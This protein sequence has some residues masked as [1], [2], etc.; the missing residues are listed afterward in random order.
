MRQ[1]KDEKMNDTKTI[2]DRFHRQELIKGWR[3]DKIQDTRIIVI[4]KDRLSD[5]LISDLMSFGIGSIKRVGYSDFLDFEKINKDVYLEQLDEE[6]SN[7]PLAEVMLKDADIVIDATND[8]RSKYYSALS[9]IKIGMRY[10]S[11]AASQSSFSLYSLKKEKDAEKESAERSIDNLI[12]HHDKEC[13]SDTRQGPQGMLNS[14][15]CSAMATDEIRKSIFALENDITMDK[16]INSD[17]IEPGELLKGKRIVQVGAG[18]IGTFTAL[19]LS[20][21]GAHVKVIDF[22]VVEETNLNRQFLFYDDI[23]K[24]KAEALTRKLKRFS[25]RIKSSK[26]KIDRTFNPENYDKGCDAI[27]SCVDNNEAR[28]YMNL[29]SKM[30][31]IPLVNGG[32]SLFAGAA[33][34]YFPGKTACLDCQT[35]NRL[36]EMER[37]K[38]EESD[39]PKRNERRLP[40]ECFQPSLIISNQVVGALMINAYAKSLKGTFERT[41]YVTGQGIFNQPIDDICKD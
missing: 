8:I 37:K 38:T 31:G 9:S 30:Y 13:R 7:Y 11:V 18:A 33:M 17:I 12:K 6:L 34:T 21:T 16:Y 23:G 25:N 35:G 4:G 15:V 40:G 5:M 29:A 22:D 27:F 14:I 39:E 41:D 36:R 26:D 2:S 10:F 20:Q 24:N 3:Q 32:S 28:Y 19:A 1:I